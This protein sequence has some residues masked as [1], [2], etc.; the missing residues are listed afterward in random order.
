MYWRQLSGLIWL[1]HPASWI[2]IQLCC[3]LHSCFCHYI[4]LVSA[5]LRSAIMLTVV[6]C[7]ML[8]ALRFPKWFQSL[9][10]SLAVRVPP[11]MSTPS[12]VSHISLFHL[13]TSCGSK[14][15]VKVISQLALTLCV[16]KMRGQGHLSVCSDLVCVKGQ[17]S[18][19]SQ[20][21]V[22]LSGPIFPT[23][24]VIIMLSRILNADYRNDCFFTHHRHRFWHATQDCVAPVA[25]LLKQVK[26]IVIMLTL[27][28]FRVWTWCEVR[29]VAAE[30][31]GVAS[32]HNIIACDTCALVGK[33]CKFV[34]MHC[35]SSDIC[36][37]RGSS[38]CA[39]HAASRCTA[40]TCTRSTLHFI[41]IRI[42]LAGTHRVQTH[43][44]LLLP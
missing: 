31:V 24:L 6:W 37:R 4:P 11:T 39:V 22:C 7:L 15:R 10:T 40:C 20:L 28:Y 44:V 16:L 14:V 27:L 25:A 19:A 36:R 8:V 13:L 43:A 12:H 17:R 29:C 18:S 23:V 42:E 32:G 34:C 1:L 2:T 41:Q 9:S 38:D 30:D 26:S 5:Q 21:C 35:V 3:L 33:R